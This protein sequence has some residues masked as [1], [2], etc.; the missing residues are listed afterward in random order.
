MSGSLKTS[1]NLIA[2]KSIDGANQ[3][4]HGTYVSTIC[5]IQSR[6]VGIPNNEPHIEC[7]K[8]VT[9]GETAFKQTTKE[10]K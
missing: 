7:A 2:M 9:A 10:N 6:I 4:T 8:A 3:L 1:F 5:P